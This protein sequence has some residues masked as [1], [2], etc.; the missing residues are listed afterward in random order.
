MS[1]F[2]YNTPEELDADAKRYRFLRHLIFHPELEEKVHLLLKD[3][4][5]D[6]KMMDL[7]IDT[8]IAIVDFKE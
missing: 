2:K 1:D 7:F 6:P 5:K 4:P 3:D 8:A